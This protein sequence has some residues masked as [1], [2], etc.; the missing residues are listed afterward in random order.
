MTRARLRPTRLAPVACDSH[1]TRLARRR[2]RGGDRQDPIVAL[3]AAAGR[4]I[5]QRHAR[6]EFCSGIV[7]VGR[8]DNRFGRLDGRFGRRDNRFGRRP[9]RPVR[10]AA[11]RTLRRPARFR[12][13]LRSSSRSV[14]SASNCASAVS[15]SRCEWLSPSGRPSCSHKWY[16]ISRMRRSRLVI[17]A[18]QVVAGAPSSPPN[19][20]PGRSPGKIIMCG[21]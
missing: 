2:R 6:P 16:A 9:R 17:A 3:E 20:P 10:P 5:G 8:L 15:Q 11:R 18:L 13:S 19:P 4:K 12:A 21:L 14:F 1:E 7:A